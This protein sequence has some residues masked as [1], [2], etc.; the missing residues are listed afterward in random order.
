MT[1]KL[2]TK[3]FKMNRMSGVVIKTRKTANS[4]GTLDPCFLLADG[5]TGR[6]ECTDRGK[7]LP[8]PGLIIARK[9]AGL[10]VVTEKLIFSI[11]ILLWAKRFVSLIEKTTFSSTCLR[12][13]AFLKSLIGVRRF[14]PRNKMDHLL[15]LFYRR[16]TYPPYNQSF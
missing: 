9:K 4:T 7:K 16:R 3:K 11:C 1:P 8:R 12:W 13:K 2:K 5:P 14:K 15:R 6:R 10:K